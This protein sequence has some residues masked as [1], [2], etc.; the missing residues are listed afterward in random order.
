MKAYNFPGQPNKISPPNSNRPIYRADTSKH[1]RDLINTLRMSEQLWNDDRTDE[2]LIHLRKAIAT[3]EFVIQN[4]SIEAIRVEYE[5]K[6]KELRGRLQSRQDGKEVVQNTMGGNGSSGKA[7]GKG[8]EEAGFRQQIE[9]AIV[10]DMPNVHW[11]DVSGLENAKNALKEAVI[12][13]TRFK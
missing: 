7:K 4:E 6:L 2:S 10:T 12:L 13:P 3:I 8:K 11:E 1:K 5:I 9:E